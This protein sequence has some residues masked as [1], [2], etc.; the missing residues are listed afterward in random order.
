MSALP[1]RAA[2]GPAAPAQVFPPVRS[3]GAPLNIALWRA[4]WTQLEAVP[5]MRGSAPLPAL[6]RERHRHGQLRLWP[7]ANRLGLLF[8]PGI[9]PHQHAGPAE[10]ILHSRA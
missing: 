1:I 10:N 7:Y 8:S 6:D 3:H 9:L 5:C 4:R 2:T